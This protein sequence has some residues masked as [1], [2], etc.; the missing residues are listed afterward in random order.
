MT[1]TISLIIPF[2]KN[3]SSISRALQSVLDQELKPMEVILVN[4][5]SPDWEIAEI[6]INTFHNLPIEVIH[7]T[8]NKNGSAARNTGIENAKGEYVAFLDAD[9]EWSPNHLSEYVKL[10][11]KQNKNALF[12]CKSI[13][14]TNDFD[15]LI[16]PD[17]G[18]EQH[19]LSDYLFVK[20]G[21]IPTPSFFIK[22]DVLLGNMF[23]EK[24]IRHQDY[25]FLFRLKEKGVKFIFSEHTGVIVHWENNDTAKKGGTSDFT[26][27]W[28]QENREWFTAK[29]YSHFMLKHVVFPIW[30][31][32]QI[33]NGTSLFFENVNIFN[34]TLKE[35]YFSVSMVLFGRIKVPW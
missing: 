9:D 32:R 18:I 25:D 20:K 14:K 7:H 27:S 1:P 34:L 16:M 21:F 31:Q 29:A 26:L 30:K 11:N 17:N 22:R 35:W 13:I 12:Y 23:N 19:K 33:K 6:T 4:D 15:D 2:Y 8:V 28:A 10:L 3:A 5:A 24:L